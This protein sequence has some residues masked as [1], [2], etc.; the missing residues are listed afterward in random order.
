MSAGIACQRDIRIYALGI[1]YYGRTYLKGKKVD[2]K[3][4]MK[5]LWYVFKFR[6]W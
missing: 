2:W 3:D 4:G 1:R 5:A 6:F